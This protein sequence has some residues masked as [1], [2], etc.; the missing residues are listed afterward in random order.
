LKLKARNSKIRV[1]I[2]TL[3]T[4][5]AFYSFF[6]NHLEQAHPSTPF[7]RF[8]SH[9]I[10]SHQFSCSHA[11]SQTKHKKSRHT[12]WHQ[13]DITDLSAEPHYSHF[14]NK[15]NHASPSP[16]C[17]IEEDDAAPHSTSR[18][19]MQIC[20]TGTISF[21]TFQP[22]VPSSHCSSHHPLAQSAHCRKS[23]HRRICTPPVHYTHN[24][25]NEHTSE[26]T[27]VISAPYHAKYRR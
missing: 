19:R 9:S 8:V 5:I 23:S 20:T 17:I 27:K 14:K 18:I 22:Q 25:I 12:T 1:Q 2:Q 3:Y 10:A 13:N 6:L 16:A 21:A 15:K 26:Q 24:R 7:A 11:R 4:R